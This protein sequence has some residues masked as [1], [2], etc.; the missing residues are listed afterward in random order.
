MIWAGNTAHLRDSDWATP[1]GVLKRYSH[2]RSIPE[3]KQLLATVPN[4]ATWGNAD[5]STR[6]AGAHYSSREHTENAF[7]AFWP[8]PSE[9]SSLDGIAT[10]FRY[11]DVEFFMLDVQLPETT[12]P[13]ANPC[14]PFSATS[15]SAGSEKN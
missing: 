8:R 11:S 7:R 13:T 14:Q 6:D 9:L 5:Y 12:A 10:R 3:L 2:A 4:Y 1:S 15:R